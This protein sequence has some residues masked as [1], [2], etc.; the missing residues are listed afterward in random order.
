[1]STIKVRTGNDLQIALHQTGLIGFYLWLL[2]SGDHI[3]IA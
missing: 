1:M 2:A 3:G